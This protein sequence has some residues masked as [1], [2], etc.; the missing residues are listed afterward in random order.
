MLYI[1]TDM[2]QT[3]AAGHMMRC[4]AI[5]DAAKSRGCC[6]TF[7]V[8]DAQAVE[9]LSER[10]YAY[11]I[12]HTP[13]DKMEEE[14][15]ALENLIKE[16]G[17]EKILIDS[18]Q[19]T[20]GY[21]RRLSEMTETFYI[22][23]LNAFF[24]PVNGL[25]CYANYWEKFEYPLRYRETKLC[26]GTQYVPL[27]REFFGCRKKQIKPQA[28]NLLLMSGGSDR[29][30][31]LSAILEQLDFAAFRRIDVICGKYNIFYESIKDRYRAHDNVHVHRA[32]SDMAHFIMQADIAV[33]AGGMTLYELCAAGT[34]AVSYSIA[35]NQLDN[36]RQFDA[37]G[38]ICYAGDARQKDI[39]PDIICRIEEYRTDQSLRAERSQRMQELVDGS[40][41][42]RIFER[43]CNVYNR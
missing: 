37:D 20:E 36:V 29:Y 23:D 10:G 1:R 39:V 4:L 34:P 3:I 31:V 35:D 32:V 16:L 9:L 14:L 24:Y 38:I 8:A 2:N 40:G 25:I 11:H 17:I 33:S 43:M 18:Y 7:L 22:D 5:A 41:A 27:R 15:P 21:L 30:G 42:E 12:L 26:L 28:E 13:W 19:V 6:T